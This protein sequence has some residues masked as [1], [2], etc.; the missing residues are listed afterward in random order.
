MS[1]ASTSISL[2]SPESQAQWRCNIGVVRITTCVS[3]NSRS[4]ESLEMKFLTTNHP[5]VIG[6]TQPSRIFPNSSALTVVEMPRMPPKKANGSSF[7]TQECDDS[8]GSTPDERVLYGCARIWSQLFLFTV[9]DLCRSDSS[10]PPT[11]TT[12]SC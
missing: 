8:V 12:F 10:Q 5:Y 9:S 6:P 1:S 7:P 3:H 2:Y 11:R 4:R